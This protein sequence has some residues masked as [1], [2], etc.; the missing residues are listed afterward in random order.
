MNSTERGK[1][2]L[3]SLGRKSN[4]LYAI[5]LTLPKVEYE[6]RQEKA[7]ENLSQPLKEAFILE[8][9]GSELGL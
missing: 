3:T 8:I 2:I 1:R 7:A 5:S 6:G 4:I 9:N